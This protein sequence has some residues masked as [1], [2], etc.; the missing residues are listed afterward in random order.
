MDLAVDREAD[1]GGAERDPRLIISIAQLWER[2]G[3]RYLV[4]A[5]GVLRDRGTDH[6]CEIVGDGPQRDELQ[7]LIG[8]LGLADR[9]V[10]TGPQPF[11]EVVRRYRGASVFV[12]PCIVTDD[13]DRDGIPNVI[14]EA[15]ASRLPVVSTAVSGIPEVIH[16]GETGLL[17]PQ[18]DPAAIADAVQRLAADPAMAAAIA[19][20]ANALVRAEFDPE[21]NVGRLLEQFEAVAGAGV[22]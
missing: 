7:S 4:E 6:R 19:E 1:G 13:G 21:R 16:D 18:R 3:L 22:P 9:V 5:C 2:K 20:R 15:M 14:L 17:V 10:L 8:R 11:P 12:L